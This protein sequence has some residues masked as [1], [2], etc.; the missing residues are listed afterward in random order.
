MK[1]KCPPRPRRRFARA[2]PPSSII[3]DMGVACYIIDHNHTKAGECYLIMSST[4]YPF[5]RWVSRRELPQSTVLAYEQ[6][7]AIDVLLGLGTIRVY[8]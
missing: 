5:K 8:N 7:L 6:G 3:L 2:I 1:R 4:P